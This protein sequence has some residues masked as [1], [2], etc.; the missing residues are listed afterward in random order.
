MREN[1]P[2][3]HRAFADI[4]Y[5]Y[6]AWGKIQAMIDQ[7]RNTYTESHAKASKYLRMALPLMH[8]YEVATN[9]HNFTIWYEYVT[10]NNLALNATLDGL[11]EAGKPF[12]EELNQ[13]IYARYFIQDEQSLEAM[14]QSMRRV[15]SEIQGQI[16]Q[17]GGNLSIY[18]DTLHFAELLTNGT[19]LDLISDTTDNVIVETRSTEQSQKQ[20]DQRLS[21]M[22]GEVETLRKEL[23]HIREESMTDGL[24]GIGNRRAFD[25]TLAKCIENAETQRA[26]F[27]ILL[28]DIDHFKRFNDTYGHLIGDRVLR[29]VANTL[30]HTVKG[31]DKPSRFGGEE[32]TVILPSTFLSGA[33]AVAEQIRK[34]IAGGNLMDKSTGESYGRVYVSIGTA[35]Y[36]KGET[37]EALIQRVDQA[38]YR[39][40]QRGRNRVEQSQ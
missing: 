14:R 32:F 15:I 3:Q 25:A 4:H 20:L 37:V 11:I 8:K 40:K 17:A 2:T 27:S 9:P 10:G 30:R 28:I 26:P 36:R 34:A 29:F 39:A 31:Y 6:C 22:A 13:D 35:Q 18:C 19:D 21:L 38:L 23:E 7:T 5:P 12:T 24:T 1:P 16:Q 33:S